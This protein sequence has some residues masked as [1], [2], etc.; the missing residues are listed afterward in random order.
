MI[1]GMDT[2]AVHFA[3]SQLRKYRAKFLEVWKPSRFH[4][5]LTIQRPIYLGNICQAG[6]PVNGKQTLF[7]SDLF[8]LDRQRG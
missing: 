8:T 5:A 2:L 6:D 4:G 7:R 3:A 1:V